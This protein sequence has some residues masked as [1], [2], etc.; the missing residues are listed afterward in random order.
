LSPHLFANPQGVGLIGGARA[1]SAALTKGVKII[2]FSGYGSFATG[3]KKK[4][5][6]QRR[7]DAK[8]KKVLAGPLDAQVNSKAS[9]FF[10]L[11]WNLYT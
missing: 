10:S 7:K 9:F 8:E 11:R 4:N 2:D 3:S 1:A 5:S 6:T